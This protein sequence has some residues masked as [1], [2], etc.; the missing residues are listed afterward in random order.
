VICFGKIFQC[1]GVDN[2]LR[3]FKEK[4]F[5]IMRRTFLILLLILAGFAGTNAQTISTAKPWTYW[6]WMG[7][8]VNKADITAQLEYFSKSGLGGVHIIPI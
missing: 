6:W 1:S 3:V 4:H 2:A 5:P 8:A 7:S